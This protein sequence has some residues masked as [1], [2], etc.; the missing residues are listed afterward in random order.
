MSLAAAAVAPGA[1][2]QTPARPRVD[3]GA[4]GVPLASGDAARP[5]FV[6]PGGDD[7]FI[8]DAFAIDPESGLL[9]FVRTDS[10][11]FAR[12][13]IADLATGRSRAAIPLGDPTRL[14][15]RVI[16][17]GAERRL[18]V[19]VR[20]PSSGKRSAQYFGDDGK[21]LG[22]VGPYSDFGLSRRG[23]QTLFVGWDRTTNGE[24]ETVHTIVR[25]RLDGPGRVGK[26]LVHVVNKAGELKKGPLKLLGW[27]DGYTRLIGQR[28]GS[29][30]PKQDVQ[31]PARAAVFDLLEGR[32]VWEAEIKDLLGWAAAN[33]LRAKRPQRSVFLV[34]PED[35]AELTLVDLFGR[36]AP[37]TLPTPLAQYDPGSLVEQEGETPGLLQFSLAVDPLNA[38]ALARGKR[39]R[40]ALD[41]FTLP[42]PAGGAA[43]GSTA[44]TRVMRLTLDARPVSWQMRGRHVALLRKHESFARGGNGLEIYGLK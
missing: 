13:E 10:A 36:R 4:G 18:V 1:R 33:V 30:D 20:D 7:G 38:E 37:V 25:H 31:V 22:L 44:A 3:A 41:L 6:V 32:F 9:A 17:A 14:Y 5:L 24:G 42:L 21:P 34:L 19:I 40:P 15:E 12:L 35:G 39:D 11:S 2:A 43:P 16:V 8:D 23:G 29:F 27:Q 28:P 26:P